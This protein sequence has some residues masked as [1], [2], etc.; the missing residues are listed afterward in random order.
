MKGKRIDAKQLPQ[1]VKK[2]TVAL[3]SSDERAADPLNLQ[4]FKEGTLL[5]VLSSVVPGPPISAVAY[6]PD[7]PSPPPPTAPIPYT[8]LPAGERAPANRPV[9]PPQAKQPKA[10]PSPVTPG[11]P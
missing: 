1:L 4:L 5:F 6:P 7:A 2:E 10:V 11:Q 3:F 8:Q 9:P